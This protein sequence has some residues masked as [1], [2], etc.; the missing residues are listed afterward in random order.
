VAPDFAPPELAIDPRSADIRSDIYSL[1]CIL[2]FTLTGKPPFPDGTPN[3]KIVAHRSKEPMPL[4]QRRPE[5]SPKLG[6]VVRKMMAKK[7]ADRYYSPA[8]VA[9]D[10][11]PFC[12]T[13]NTAVKRP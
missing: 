2:Y 5:V 8:E 3:D 12:V 4:E 10:L 6:V 1:G 9:N 7:P 11:T 13:G